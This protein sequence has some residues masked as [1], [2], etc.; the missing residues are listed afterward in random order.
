M[1]WKKYNNKLDKLFNNCG[2]D[3]LE[4]MGFP[5]W[6]NKGI[7]EYVSA[8]AEYDKKFSKFS[9]E[10]KADKFMSV[11]KITASE[12]IEILKTKAYDIVQ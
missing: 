8:L 1:K 4:N 10:I 9:A 3:M 11:L 5:I 12:L 6:E 2:F 7:D